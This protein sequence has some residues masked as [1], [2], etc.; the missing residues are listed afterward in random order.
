VIKEIPE[1]YD[2][3][4]ANRLSFSAVLQIANVLTP[5]NKKELL[6]RIELKSK[7]EIEKII[8]EHQAPQAIPD[9]ARP[10]LVKKIASVQRASGPE[11]GENSLR[12]EGKFD[13]TDKISTP[14]IIIEKMFEVRFAADDEL[15]ELIRW[16][17]SYLSHKY[18]NGASFQEIFKFALSYLREREDLSLQDKPRRTNAKTDTRYIAKAVKQQVWKRDNGRCA[19]VGSNGKRCNSTHN[20]EYDHH[21]V[22]YAR[23]G[24]STVDNLRLLCAKHNK[25]A[26]IK[27][28]GEQTIKKHY[29]KE[30]P[31]T[32]ITGAWK[33]PRNTTGLIC[34]PVRWPLCGI[35]PAGP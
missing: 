17:K 6:P 32:Y 5:E 28:Y 20:L 8:V 25:H 30:A 19:F 12:C 29:I 3:M 1:V 15:M 24:P 34:W 22:P 9:S 11:L 7:S 21:P 10:K 26:A 18:P 16:A 4:K 13:P 2:L 27:T 33:T 14:E 23:G 35:S 31:V